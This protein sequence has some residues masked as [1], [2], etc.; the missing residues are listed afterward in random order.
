M[1]Y[2]REGN[3]RPSP[4]KVARM[5]TPPDAG[6]PAAPAGIS[7][8]MIL[9]VYLLDGAESISQASLVLALRRLGHTGDAARQAIAR[10]TRRGLLAA[11][12]HGRHA[13]MSLTPAGVELLRDGQH[14]LF[15]F[16]EPWTWDGRWLLVSVRVPEGRRDARHRLRKRLGWA[17]FGSLGNGL[18]LSPHPDSEPEVARILAEDPAVQAWTFLA[19]HGELGDLDQLVRQAWDIDAMV[20]NYESFI[21]HFSRVRARTAEQCFVALTSMLTRWREFPFIDPDLP[22]ELLP[23][24]RLRERAHRVFHERRNRWIG[25]MRRYLASSEP[26]DANASTESVAQGVR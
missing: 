19:R 13:H 24:G 9:G 15:T 14:R 6:A 4:G 10:A 20:A 26:A 25:P 16:G 8:L 5:R 3:A 23:R 22:P 21:N 18:W 2:V 17:G 7:L 1:S 11:E 12:R